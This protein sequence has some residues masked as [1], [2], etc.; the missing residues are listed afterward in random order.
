MKS[1]KKYII[2][3]VLYG[4]IYDEVFFDH[5]L[6]SI[7][8]D[9]NIPSILKD[10]DIHYLIYTTHEK[11]AKIE[12][13]EN[14]NK[15]SKLVKVTANPVDGKALNW[16]FDSRYSVLQNTLRHAIEFAIKEKAYLSP[17]CADLVVAKE[18]FPRITK[19]I[20]E[21]Y[22][23]VNVLPMRTASEAM[24]PELKK[25]NGALKDLDLF[26]LGYAA[27]HPIWGA[28]HW[29]AAQFTRLPFCILWNNYPGLLVRS[30]SISPTI[31]T[32]NSNM[33]GCH[34]IDSDVPGF[35]KNAFLANDWIDAP[36]IN[37]EPLHC[38]YPIFQ[39]KQ[40]NSLKYAKFIKNEWLK[41][42]YPNQIE[43]LEEKLYYPCR[44]KINISESTIKQS[45]KIVNTIIK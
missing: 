6:G 9:S 12:L 3:N 34:M 20:N 44:D 14:I 15:L 29:D 27:L 21:G 22:D 2:T 43:Y 8:D 5:H 19:K 36:I 31:F 41:N 28:C 39:N 10:F 35:L 18:F 32:P 24:I 42:L 16:V 40:A 7:L 11:L 37:V 23:S 1:K 30:F 33:M 38:Y 17:L 4:N 26:K 25:V 45:N 13:N